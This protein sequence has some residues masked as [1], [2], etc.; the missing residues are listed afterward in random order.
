MI[1]HQDLK[2]ANIMVDKTTLHVKVCDF[3]LRQMRRID[4]VSRRLAQSLAG[5]AM[6]MAPECLVSMFKA[7][8][9]SDI[10]AFGFVIAE[11]QA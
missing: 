3:G 4:S 10:W 2:P 6:Y 8:K 5:T 9:S 7:T 11:L 1:I